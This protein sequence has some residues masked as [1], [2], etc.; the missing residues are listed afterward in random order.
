MSKSDY[1]FWRYYK[2]REFMHLGFEGL[3]GDE[4]I[5]Q[6]CV[7][8]GKETIKR[9]DKSVIALIHIKGATITPSAM[10]IIKKIGLTTQP[11]FIRSAIIGNTG[12]VTILIQIYI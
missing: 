2:G 7:E 9:P 4:A 3:V 1:Q 5:I 6:R 12:L 10:R 11:K 8:G